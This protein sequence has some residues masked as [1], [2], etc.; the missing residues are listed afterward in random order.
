RPQ[1]SGDPAPMQPVRTPSFTPRCLF[2]LAAAALLGAASGAALGATEPEH[3][4]PPPSTEPP[5]P[6]TDAPKGDTGKSDRAKAKARME[7]ACKYAETA[8]H[9]ASDTACRAARQAVN[10]FLEVSEQ[11]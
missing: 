5:H 8:M 10:A 3:S 11:A 9:K 6:K 7:Q 4:T 1:P 2:R